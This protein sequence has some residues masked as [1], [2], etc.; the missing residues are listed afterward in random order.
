MGNEDVIQTKLHN[1]HATL[2]Q[3]GNK[4][5]L[6]YERVR[7]ILNQA[8]IRTRRIPVGRCK[9]CSKPVPVRKR[10]CSPECRHDYLYVK[11]VCETCNKSFE[12][13]RFMVMNDRH[14]RDFC[15]RECFGKYAGSHYGWGKGK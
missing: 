8:G 1:P 3:I 6:S 4:H 10:Y 7:V 5:N 13:K 15:S 12:K 11:V 9:A 14:Q 2:R